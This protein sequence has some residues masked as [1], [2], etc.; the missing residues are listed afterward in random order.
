MSEKDTFH[1]DETRN[2]PLERTVWKRMARTGP[3]AT[4]NRLYVARFVSDCHSV[5]YGPT[6]SRPR[7]LG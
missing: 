3:V 1:H 5:S 4:P 7:R 6:A 2:L